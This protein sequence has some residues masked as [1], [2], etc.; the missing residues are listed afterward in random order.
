MSGMSATNPVIGIVCSDIHLSHKPPLA[1]SNE[2][3][4]YGVMTEYLTQLRVLQLQYACPVFIAGDIFHQ[5]DS[6]AELINLALRE[7]PERVYAIPGQHDLP[8]HNYADIKKSAYWTLV[9]AE[10]ITNLKPGY[11]PVEC[12]DEIISVYAFP[13]N[14]EI[15]PP[16]K[17]DKTGFKLALVHA[18]VWEKGN[19][20]R[21]A[22]KEQ[23]LF[24]NVA[25]KLD[26]YTVAAFGDNHKGFFFMAEGEGDPWIINCGAF[27][28]RRMDEIDYEPQVGL[29]HL[30]GNITIHKLDT[31]L[32]SFID[33]DEALSV[34]EHAVD[35]ADLLEELGKLGSKVVDFV[36]A[37][38][39]FC[40]RNNVAKGVRKLLT[41]TMKDE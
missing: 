15:K 10:K 31:Q 23:K 9:E 41:E 21:G 32:D 24:P 19:K 4:W 3:D 26:G 11:N 12:L 39:Q 7:L 25:K 17:D 36:E 38:N 37:V 33:M 16:D 22:P 8:L 40:E 30:K 27:I 5:S 18:Y 29:L 1:R 20:Y 34:I 13:W 6:P 2:E 35:A 28:K 14:H